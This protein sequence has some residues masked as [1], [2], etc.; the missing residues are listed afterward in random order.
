MDVTE[1]EVV[2][3]AQAEASLRLERTNVLLRRVA[4]LTAAALVLL[5]AATLVYV[6]VT[7]DRAARA[8]A[9]STDASEGNRRLLALLQSESD[10]RAADL[11]ASQQGLR[12][13]LAEVEAARLATDAR[14]TAQLQLILDLLTA[15]VRDPA[16]QEN[17]GRAPRLQDASNP[18]PRAQPAPSSSRSPSPRPSPGRSPSPRPSPSP[19]CATGQPVLG[20]CV[21]PP[22]TP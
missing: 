6:V 11:L 5:S 2:V 7:A 1:V 15:E 12:A 8:A 19:S 17:R 18:S 14:R 21:P 4:V 22:R 3:A 13:G 10:A 20:I 16:N 9:A